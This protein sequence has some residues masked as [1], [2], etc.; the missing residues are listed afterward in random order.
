M[1][2]EIANGGLKLVEGGAKM[3]SEDPRALEQDRIIRQR[4]SPK[5]VLRL[6]PLLEERRLEFGI[7]DR[8]FQAQAVYDRVF[9]FQ[10]PM[11]HGDKFE[12]SSLYMP[13]TT[14]AREMNGAPRGIIISA[15]AIALDSL[16]SNGV[17]LG[18][19]VLFVNAAPY[20]I[21]YDTIAGQMKNLI[22]LTAGDIV[23]SEDLTQN[24]RSAAVRIVPKLNA[25]GITT[26]EYIDETGKP[27]IP[28]SAWQ[29]DS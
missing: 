5:G 16:R 3:D 14:K 21:R 1:T 25:A 12:G 4:M 26:H 11:V 23:A 19:I 20:H 8:A 2:T 24:L 7:T 27:W 18:H 6:P 10:L 29:A 9:V 15:G 28:Q 17:D 13:D 22:V